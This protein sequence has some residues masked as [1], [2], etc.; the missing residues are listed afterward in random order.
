[1]VLK[2]GQSKLIYSQT[3]ITLIK[4]INIITYFENVIIKLYVIYV[5]IYMLNFMLIECYLLL[6][7]KIEYFL[8][9]ILNFKN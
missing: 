2:Q 6:D 3:A 8:Y 7:P 5:L 4:K 9:I 1:M